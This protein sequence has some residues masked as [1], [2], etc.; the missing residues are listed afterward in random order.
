MLLTVLSGLV[1]ALIV[2]YV[3]REV[4]RAWRLTTSS[5]GG[6]AVPQLPANVAEF[7]AR[8]AYLADEIDPWEFEARIE[9][10]LRNPRPNP[11]KPS[12]GARGLW[13]IHAGPK[14]SGST[15]YLGAGMNVSEATFLM[16]LAKQGAKGGR[17]PQPDDP[18]EG[19][20]TSREWP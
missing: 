19:M 14:C 13:Q 10:A 18:H 15:H 6:Y 2:V 12:S 11:T 20:R 17:V 9:A 1:C 16:W 5:S 8:R 4:R 7:E 3:A